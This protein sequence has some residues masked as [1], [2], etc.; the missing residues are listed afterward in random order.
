[1]RKGRAKGRDRA[2]EK[3][4][5][6]EE[7]EEEEDQSGLSQIETEGS[8]TTRERDGKQTSRRMKR[9]RQSRCE[10]LGGVKP[11]GI[12]ENG[13]PSSLLPS[14]SLSRASFFGF[15]GSLRG[16]KLTD[17]YTP[18]SVESHAQ[19]GEI[20]AG[21]FPHPDLPRRSRTGPGRLLIA[22]CSRGRAK[23]NGHGNCRAV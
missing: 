21:Y 23:P 2:G 4:Q 9:E 16:K 20:T 15:P 14:C 12:F 11:P 17:T 6:E 8:D 13:S 7:E 5:E 3:R 1:M 19:Q 22:C 18:L 10:I